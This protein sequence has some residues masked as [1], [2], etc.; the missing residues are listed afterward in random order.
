MLYRCNRSRADPNSTLPIGIY[1]WWCNIL[2]NVPTYLCHSA[3]AFPPCVSWGDHRSAWPL[4]R[5]CVMYHNWHDTCP[6]T[7]VP[8]QPR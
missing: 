8:G 4:A 5:T 2:L 3:Q 1:Y 6:T 7:L